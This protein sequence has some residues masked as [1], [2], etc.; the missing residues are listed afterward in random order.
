[1]DKVILKNM[2]FD[3]PVGLDAWRRF[4]KPQP[5]LITIEAQP[6]S[7]LEPAAAKDDVN[8]SMDYGKLYKKVSSSLKAADPDA[9]PTVR[10]LISHLVDLVSG[11]GVLDID[12][13]FP[14]ALPQSTGGVLY[15]FQV[16]KSEIEVDTSSLALT[17]KQIA[18][19]CIVGV[20]PHERIYKQTVYVDISIP[21]VDPAVG[22]GAIE[23]H[24]TAALH[25]MVQTIWE[26][27]EGS[28]YHTIEALAT[29]AAQVVTVNYGHTVAKVRIEKPSAIASIEAAGVEIT[30]SKTFF[31]NKDFWKVKLP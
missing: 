27:V 24:Y 6:T 5:V 17:V 1:M 30:R 31:E 21:M 9:F 16:D 15:R 13:L 10:A 22:V 18:C 3:I 12:L 7:T 25:D 2:P 19:N 20:N 8:L 14:K 26:R 11:C 23:E 4:H 28:T 29:A